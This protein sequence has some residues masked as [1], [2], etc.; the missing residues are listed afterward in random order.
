VSVAET[1]DYG[2][3]S[4]LAKQ[5]VISLYGTDKPSPEEVRQNMGFLKDI[6]RGNCRYVV[7]YGGGER[8]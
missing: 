3:A 1:P 5:V 2:V 8:R 4:P 7:L 6:D